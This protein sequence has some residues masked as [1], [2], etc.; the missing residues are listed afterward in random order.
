MKLRILLAILGTT[1][2]T[3]LVLAIPLGRLIVSSVGDQTNLKLTAVTV[4][5]ARD[6][7]KD[8]AA[9][10]S[11]VDIPSIGPVSFGL[12]DAQGTRLS[13]TG[14]DVGDMVVRRALV[15]DVA[16]FELDDRLFTAIPLFLHG[17]V[18]G[19]LRASEPDRVDEAQVR[20]SFIAVGLACLAAL[21][22]GSGV[23]IAVATRLSRPVRLLSEA[24]EQIGQG[25]SELQVP[26]LDI[27]ELEAVGRTLSATN[28]RVHQLLERERAFS[29]DASHQLRTPLTGIRANI[30][31]ELQFPREDSSL[32]LRETLADV[33]R[34]EETVK[35]LLALAR[36]DS[37]VRSGDVEA[38]L[39]AVDEAWRDR[40]AREG[41]VLLIDRPPVIPRIRGNPQALRHALDVLLDN[42]TVH[43][44]G[45]VRVR[46]RAVNDEVTIS[47]SDEGEG[48]TRQHSVGDGSH[49]LGLP[50]A[51]RLIEGMAG[52]VTVDDSGP[53]P[54][55]TITVQRDDP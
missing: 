30:E 34:L 50:L 38:V 28:L 5:A 11:P 52:R 47:V 9:S 35:D 49:G 19:A 51:A 23:A 2:L 41:R 55:V 13:G 31:T 37:S 45:T 3:V 4:K 39:T 12:Y 46:C 29:S 21:L 20:S 8:F 10:R 16:Y 1:A 15:D 32:V 7:P 43:G 24:A 44:A 17:K 53:G 27:P 36:A 14:P 6:V 22:I 54:V 26:H 18:V 25:G 42:A 40:L 48:F 33:D